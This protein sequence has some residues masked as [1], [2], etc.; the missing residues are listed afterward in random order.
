MSSDALQEAYGSK[1]KLGLGLAFCGLLLS[2]AEPRSPE[3][4]N[5]KM[6][7][8]IMFCLSLHTHRDIYIYI[9]M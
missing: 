9:Y 3:S 5:H 2:D 8:Y 1:K 6:Y 7:D 4:S